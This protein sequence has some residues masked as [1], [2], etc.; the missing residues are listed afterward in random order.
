MQQVSYVIAVRF[1]RPINLF[2]SFY[3][4]LFAVSFKVYECFESPMGGEPEIS[5]LGL[6]IY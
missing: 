3:Q 4:W 6:N 2:V 1:L 5:A